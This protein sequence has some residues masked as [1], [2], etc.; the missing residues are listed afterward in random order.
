MLAAV[1]TPF[2]KVVAPEPTKVV[3]KPVATSSERMRLFPK[4]AM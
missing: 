1:P 4:S 3:T 2:A